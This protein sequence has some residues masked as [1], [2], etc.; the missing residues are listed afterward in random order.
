MKN[1]YLLIAITIFLIPLT[2]CSKNSTKYDDEN[3]IGDKV[4]NN[5]TYR[6]KKNNTAEIIKFNNKSS[7][8]SLPNSITIKG[9]DYL[10]TSIANKAFYNSNK[11]KNINISDNIKTIGRNAFDGCINL[12][13]INL[14]K[15]ETIKS[16]AFKDCYNLANIEI[17]KSIE[18]IEPFAFNNAGLISFNVDINNNYFSSYQGDLYSKDYKNF[19]HYAGNKENEKVSLKEGTTQIYSGAFSNSKHI[20]EIVLPSSLEI[21]NEY[22]FSHIANL[23]NVTFNNNLKTIKSGAFYDCIEL[24]NAILPSSLETIEDYAF[25]NCLEL[26]MVYIPKSVENIGQCPFLNCEQIILFA[27]SMSSLSTWSSS[28]REDVNNVY[29]NAILNETF[30]LNESNGLIYLFTSD[31][32]VKIVGHF[33]EITSLNIPDF[34]ISNQKICPIVS[35]EAKAF[36]HNKKLEEIK[37]GASLECINSSA[38]EECINLKYVSLGQSI[39]NLEMNSFAKCKNLLTF[40]IESNKLSNISSGAFKDSP[41]NIFN[42]YKN[43][44]YIGNKESKYKYLIKIISK[45][46]DS[47]ETHA[48]TLAIADEAFSYNSSL[49]KLTISAKVTSIGNYCLYSSS[50]ETIKFLG[51]MAEFNNIKKGSVWQNKLFKIECSDGTIVLKDKSNSN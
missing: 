8:I 12:K 9:Q 27:E 5:I 10:V 18:T 26:S 1:K 20:K 51:T 50:L 43:A 35:I 2:S 14:N 15:V 25:A 16:Y 38:F 32:Y 28:W 40:T 49:K 36:T 23:Q 22:A 6:Y 48:D 34:V 30:F 24:N 4:L 3:I 45:G 17:T 29:Y 37:G 44:Y 7:N 13:T 46:L 41:T 31:N 19:I 11:L 42:V 21:I 33:E 39:T 47:C